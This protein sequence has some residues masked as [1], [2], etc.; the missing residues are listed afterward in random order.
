[1]N[2]K[3]N[4]MKKLIS[5][6]II[7]CGFSGLFGCFCS[8][9]AEYW[10]ITDIEIVLYDQNGATPMN[11]TMHGDSI[12]I[13]I[14]FVPEF[15]AKPASTLYPLLNSAWAFSCPFPGDRGLQYR[16]ESFT[17]TSSADFNTFK[18]GESLNSIIRIPGGNRI[19]DLISDKADWSH[20]YYGRIDL[21]VTEKPLNTHLHQFIVNIALESGT[22]VESRSEEILWQ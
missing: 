18:A 21:M 10:N 2:L 4:M 17:V 1:M 16:I 6:S 5:F 11:G 14:Y 8:D 19:E 22:I 9:I 15:V 12:G 20:A 13:N 3:T 7:Y